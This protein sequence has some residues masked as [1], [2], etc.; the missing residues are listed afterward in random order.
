MT[1][2]LLAVLATA[3]L[4]AQKMTAPQLITL[5]QSHSPALQDAINAGKAT[6]ADL[7]NLNIGTV[8]TLAAVIVAHPKLGQ[9]WDRRG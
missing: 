1:A 5:A 2:L 6:A 8:L 9:R 3:N 7:A 4:T